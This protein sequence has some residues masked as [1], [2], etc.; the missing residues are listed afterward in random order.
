VILMDWIFNRKPKSTA[1]KFNRDGI[2]KKCRKQIGDKRRK[3]CNKCG[4]FEV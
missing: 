3:L 4:E 1:G 2:C